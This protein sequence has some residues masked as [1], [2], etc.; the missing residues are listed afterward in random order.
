MFFQVFCELLEFRLPSDLDLRALK[1]RKRAFWASVLAVL[2]AVG[3]RHGVRRKPLT[4]LRAV[5]NVGV[6]SLWL[7]MLGGFL[8]R[9]QQTFSKVT[10]VLVVFESSMKYLL[11]NFTWLVLGC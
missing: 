8:M 10:I 6:A 9:K 1:L 3:W 4:L 7:G 11:I 5:T 2:Y